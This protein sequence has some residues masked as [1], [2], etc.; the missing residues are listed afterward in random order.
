M[1]D[2]LV[3]I[4]FLELILLMVEK[5]EVQKH[6]ILLI[7]KL[8]DIQHQLLKNH[9]LKVEHHMFHGILPQT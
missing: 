4:Q 6:L 1:L 5:M 8:K 9:L 2:S 7:Q 3:V